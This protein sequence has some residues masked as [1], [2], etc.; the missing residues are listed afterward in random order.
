VSERDGDAE[1]YTMR[2]DGSRQVNRTRNPAFD[3]DPDR[4]PLQEGRH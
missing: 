2:A 3:V 1:I 4:Q